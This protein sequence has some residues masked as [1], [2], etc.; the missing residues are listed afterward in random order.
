M[1]EQVAVDR[2]SLADK[3]G[4]VTGASSGL[5]ASFARILHGA[6]A[7]VVLAA[8][9]VDR[10]DALSEELNAQR[11]GQQSA[12]SVAMDV[13]DTASVDDGFAAGERAFGSIDIVVNN[14]GVPSGSYFTDITDAEW[15]G[16]MDV[17]LDGVFRVARAGA[18]RMRHRGA[19]G[20]I[21]NIASVLGVRVLKA[22]APYATSKAAVIQL[23]K[24]MAIELAR[25]QIRVNAIAPG[26]FQTEINDGFLESEP[27]RKLLASIPYGRPGLHDELAGPL[28][29]LASDAG[30]YM[31][32]TVVGVDGGAELKMG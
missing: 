15:R 8:R 25:E 11:G 2:F 3:T 26:Y 29:L 32:G 31:T 24:A 23:T 1:A 28:L 21:I 16:V 9:R 10:L 7:N 13:T 14:A 5:G 22:L 27:G 19:G 4:L 30:A 20:S 6:G 12:L 18:A 17:N